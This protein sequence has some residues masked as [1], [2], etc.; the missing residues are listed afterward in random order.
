MTDGGAHREGLEYILRQDHRERINIA[1]DNITGH[2]NI[3]ILGQEAMKRIFFS[4][5]NEADYFLGNYRFRTRGYPFK[6]EIYSVDL[7]G[8]KLL[9]VYKLR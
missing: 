3:L 5:P 1:V 8:A 4:P 6:D 7:D 2:F 9:S